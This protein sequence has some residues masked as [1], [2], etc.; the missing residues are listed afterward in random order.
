MS[1]FTALES[2]TTSTDLLILEL[3]PVRMAWSMRRLVEEIDS[4]RQSAG[5]LSPTA[6]EMMSPGT[7]SEAWMRVTFPSRK[8][9]ASSGE[10]SFKAYNFE[11]QAPGPLCIAG[12]LTSMACSAFVSWITPTAAL[13]TRMRRMTK[14]STNALHQLPSDSSKSAST[15]EMTADAR[16]MRTSW[17]LNCSRM[18]SHSGVDG[19]S[20]SSGRRLT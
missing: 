15:N 12:A 6:T 5:T 7:S 17:S 9:L 14:G 13:A 3:S 20:G 2:A 18:S 10:Y 19:S 1:C 16:R 8:A 4:R 11:A